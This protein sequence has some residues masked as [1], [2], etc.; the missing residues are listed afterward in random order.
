MGLEQSKF[1]AQAISKAQEPILPAWMDGY[2]SAVMNEIIAEIKQTKN[3]AAI[4]F[5]KE[6]AR[7]YALQYCLH[8]GFKHAPCVFLFD[9]R[10]RYTDEKLKLVTGKLVIDNRTVAPQR[11]Q[12]IE[13]RIDESPL[14]WQRWG[15]KGWLSLPTEKEDKKE[16]IQ[17]DTQ[18]AKKKVIKTTKQQDPE[19]K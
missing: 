9:P 13:C 3:F 10:T 8:N 5:L 7:T 19:A 11:G 18:P 14:I 4:W 15:Q 6:P 16:D 2:G 12:T 17:E 1:A